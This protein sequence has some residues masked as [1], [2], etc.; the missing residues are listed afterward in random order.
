MFNHLNTIAPLLLKSIDGPRG[1]IYT[2]PS[3]NKYPSITTILGSG[4]KPWLA[5]W[6]N[7]LGPANADKEMKRAADR[8]TA[9]HLMLE[10]FINNETDPTRNQHIDHINEFKSLRSY[11]KP[12]DNILLQEAAL[13]SDTL[14]VAGRVD[15]IAD[16]KGKISIIDWKTSTRSKTQDMIKNYYLQTTAYALMVDEIY[17]IV[18]EDIVILMSVEKGGMPLIFKGKV[19]D[20]VEN[21]LEKLHEYHN[22]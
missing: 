8:G 10:R 6:R 3:G 5:D 15:L 21:L 16:Y 12:I 1:R 20:Y 18:I 17:D 4:E 2:T 9:V 7:S 19:D 13:Y 14:K 22:K 11:I